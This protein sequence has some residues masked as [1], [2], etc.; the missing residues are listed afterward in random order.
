M[1]AADGFDENKDGNDKYF[2]HNNY[3]RKSTDAIFT[4]SILSKMRKITTIIIITVNEN[5]I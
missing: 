4:L 5:K 3:T 1:I 2:I